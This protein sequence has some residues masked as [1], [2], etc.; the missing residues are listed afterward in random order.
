MLSNPVS[1]AAR[2]ISASSCQR[3]SRS[4]SGSC[5]PSLI[6][7]GAGKAGVSA[8]RR[9]R[10]A[11]A[12]SCPERLECGRVAWNRDDLTPDAV[13]VRDQEHLVDVEAPAESRPA[14]AI[15]GD[16]VLVVRERPGELTQICA[17][18]QAPRLPEQLE[19]AVASP[20]AR[21]DGNRAVDV[22]AA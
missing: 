15:D 7:S 10:R 9:L 18:R 21:R 6:R 4:T 16:G 8:P 17:V 22:P 13:A 5:T 12:L 11:Y 19:D 1:S 2:A 14:G 20:V 3:T